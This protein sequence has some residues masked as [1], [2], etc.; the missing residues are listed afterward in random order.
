MTYDEF[1]AAWEARRREFAATGATLDGVKVVDVLLNELDALR[2]TEGAR[3]LTLRE[4]SNLSGYSVEHL[5]LLIRT[6]ALTNAGSK[7]R[8]RIYLH[9]LPMKPK[10]SVAKTYDVQY[11]VHADAQALRSQR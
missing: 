10:S 4:A 3:I 5:G 1:V 11:D 2:T 9:D 8:P 6:G 7:G